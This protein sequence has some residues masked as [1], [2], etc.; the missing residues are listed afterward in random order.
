MDKIIFRK[1]LVQM[2]TFRENVLINRYSAI[3]HNKIQFLDH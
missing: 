1:I 2:K 3:F